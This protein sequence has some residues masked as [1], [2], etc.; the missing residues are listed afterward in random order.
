MEQTLAIILEETI[1]ALS[2]LD[3]DRLSLLEKEVHLLVNAGAPI[4]WAPVVERHQILRHLLDKTK[5]NIAVLTRLN[6]G[7][8]WSEW[9]R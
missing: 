4:S 9:E 5:A 2:I 7:N 6:Q 1:E 3:R 8:G